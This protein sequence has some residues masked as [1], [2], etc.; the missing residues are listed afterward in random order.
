MDVPKLFKPKKNL[1]KKVQDLIKGPTIHNYKDLEIEEQLEE[2]KYIYVTYRNLTFPELKNL[3]FSDKT[4]W[5]LFS[6]FDYNGKMFWAKHWHEPPKADRISLESSET[7]SEDRF[8][9]VF[10]KLF[11]YNQRKSNTPLWDGNLQRLK[12]YISYFTIQSKD[13]K[14]NFETTFHELYSKEFQNAKIDY[15]GLQKITEKELQ[16]IKHL[17][18]KL[19]SK[20]EAKFPPLGLA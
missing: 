3:N 7:E 1:Q 16:S 11:G 8:H 15:I 17:K 6:T 4:Y 5:I 14:T 10:K 9:E 13:F 20:V 18:H 12:I 19:V 2:K